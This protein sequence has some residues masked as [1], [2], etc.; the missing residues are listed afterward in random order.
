[1]SYTY[2][3]NLSFLSPKKKSRA[4]RN[5]SVRPQLCLRD[6]PCV[7]RSVVL[8]RPS[9]RN[10]KSIFHC[11]RF[12][13]GSLPRAH[14]HALLA[15]FSLSANH[16][17]ST[18]LI[19]HCLRRPRAPMRRACSRRFHGFPRQTHP[20]SARRVCWS[21]GVFSVLSAQKCS[22]PVRSSRLR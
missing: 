22:C 1:M 10:P 3:M 16:C 20:F 14:A 19:W 17:R 11:H 15:A 6:E 7:A 13:F 2:G 9:H 5:L 8:C 4:F 21:L 12:V 18:S